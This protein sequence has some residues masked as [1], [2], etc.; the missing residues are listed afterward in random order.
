MPCSICAK[1]KPLRRTGGHCRSCYE[2]QLRQSNPEFAARQRVNAAAWAAK[3][4]ERIAEHKAR[5]Y[6]KDRADPTFPARMRDR[7]LRRAYGLSAAEV[8]SLLAAG[9]S[10][11]GGF[12]RLRVD[13]DHGTGKVRG[14]LCHSCNI[15]LGFVERPKQWLERALDYLRR[16]RDR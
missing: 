3:H 15:G 12:D 5:R 1:D 6:A 11:C 9:C 7:A 16:T 4:P 8:D 14:G 13:H 10:I 2:R